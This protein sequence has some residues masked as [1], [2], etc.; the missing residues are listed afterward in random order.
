MIIALVFA[1]YILASKEKLK[2]QFKNLFKAYL[3]PKK[4]EMVINVLRITK[5]TFS[6][7]FTVQCLE[8]TILGS[9]CIIGMFILQIPYAIQI[10]VL[11]GVT[12]LIPIV[13]AFIGMLVGA[14]LIVSI[15]PIK[16]IT[17]V[18]FVLILQQVEGN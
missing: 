12:A 6:S 1:A 15:E 5:N 13:G 7:F 17:F 11:I 14:I 3:S 2:T 16:V 10:G 18:V 4:Y 9:L 8:A